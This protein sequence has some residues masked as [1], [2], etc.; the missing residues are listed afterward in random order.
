MP[1]ASSVPSIQR[2]DPPATAG[3]MAPR[4]APE[5]GGTVLAS[6]IEPTE[7]GHRLRIARLDDTIW[8]EPVSIV[9]GED[10]FANWADT[11]GV[12]PVGDQL[13]A[14]WP[15][16]L[17]EG[18]YAY[19]LSIAHGSETLSAAAEFRRAGLLHD[20]ATPEEHGF[21]SFVPAG[22]GAVRAFWLDGRELASHGNGPR[23]SMQLRSTTVTATADGVEIAPSTVLDRRVCECCSTDAVDTP[24]GPLVAYRDRDEGEIRDIYVVRADGSGEGSEPVRVHED[25][26][27]IEGCPVNGPALDAAGDI[28]AIAWFTA[29]EAPRVVMAWSRDG[30]ASFEPPIEI[31][32]TGTALGRVDLALDSAGDAWVTWL[33]VGGS[34]PAI[35]LRRIG[36]GGEIGPARTVVATTD[37]RASGVPRLVA[38][39]DRLLIAWVE[40]AEASAL[41]VAA[42]PLS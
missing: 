37:R 42:V 32:G 41:R 36:R 40:D 15:E 5:A 34:G 25:G 35:R 24:A 1:D 23:G 3:A 17:G 16:M 7:A 6:W 33:A 11:P 9:E 10:F 22:D 12:T 19:G 31:D 21:V 14:A 27:R 26:W 28:V 13:V 38:D 30:G 20:D 39:G 18:T 2:L 4:L 29:A 8:S